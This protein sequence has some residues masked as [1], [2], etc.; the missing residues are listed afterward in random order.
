ML[1][2]SP[3]P[4]A[5][6][7]HSEVYRLVLFNF[8]CMPE[9]PWA[10]IERM[11]EP[12]NRPRDLRETPRA[13]LDVPVAEC[14]AALKEFVDEMLADLRSAEQQVVDEVDIPALVALT[15]ATA[16][17]KDPAQAR[18]F[19]RL[20]GEYR[21]T[22]YKGLDRL[23]AAQKEKGAV[24][25][26]TPGGQE[27]F[28]SA[29]TSPFA[30][31]GASAA[32]RPGRQRKTAD[33]ETSTTVGE[34]SESPENAGFQATETSERQGGWWFT[35]EVS[36]ESRFEP[37]RGG[38][39]P[40]DDPS[41]AVPTGSVG[42]GAGLREGEAAAER[43]HEQRSDWYRRRMNTAGPERNA[44][45]V[46]VGERAR[47]ATNADVGTKAPWWV[48]TRRLRAAWPASDSDTAGAERGRPPPHA[49]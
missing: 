2:Y 24:P 45:Q 14:R 19:Q 40:S 33:V 31:A 43:E 39:A 44:Q 21:T 27:W 47:P 10:E 11:L 36:G 29:R 5:V 49:G 4:A 35:T 6:A 1:G 26:G 25:G 18:K 3:G 17:I 7:E 30:G 20:G 12:A 8:L 16:V 42:D 15:E 9:P 48:P 32:A 34:S 28:R 37:S 23:R 13:E 22:L 46:G 41:G 38:D